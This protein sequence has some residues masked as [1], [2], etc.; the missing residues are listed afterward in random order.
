M[1][2]LTDPSIANHLSSNRR[3][4]ENPGQHRTIQAVYNNFF[5]DAFFLKTMGILFHLLTKYV[6]LNGVCPGWCSSGE[7]FPDPKPYGVNMPGA[8]F[9]F[10]VSEL[11]GTQRMA[12]GF[13][14]LCFH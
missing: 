14:V 2:V 7:K 8:V 3:T 6:G 12:D 11:S 10:T 13:E 4:K 1:L 9:K 5:N